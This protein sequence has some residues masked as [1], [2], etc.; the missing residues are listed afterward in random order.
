MKVKISLFLISALS[1]IFFLSCDKE[2][3]Y[4]IALEYNG[5]LTL[6]PTFWNVLTSDSYIDIDEPNH[7]AGYD[8]SLK[9]LLLSEEALP[10]LRRLEFLTDST[11]MVRFQDGNLSIDTIMPYIK[12]PNRIKILLGSLPGE[13]IVFSGE[14]EENSLTLGTVSTFYSFK[15]SNAEV[16][17][18]PI[19]VQYLSGASVNDIINDLRV[20]ENLM[21]GDT[22]AV[23][24]SGYTFN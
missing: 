8:E 5:L 7:L 21:P 3:K 11:V 16:E 17:Y 15:L 10:P 4:P 1:S 24:K 9:T 6:G 13:E 20:Q 12:S 22:V 23:T 19:S 18:S 14:P 2:N